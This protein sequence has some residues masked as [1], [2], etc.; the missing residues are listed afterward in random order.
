MDPHPVIVI[1][2]DNRD[3]IRVL[4]Y[5]YYTTITGW[6]VLLRAGSIHH[7]A[8]GTTK[9]YGWYVKSLSTPYLGAI[10]VGEIDLTNR[11]HL[12]L[13]TDVVLK[14]L[15]EGI[16]NGL[17]LFSG[18]CCILA[19]YSNPKASGSHHL[20]PFRTPCSANR[21]GFWEDRVQSLG[22]RV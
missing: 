19:R 1:I 2:R 13:A 8:M 15:T 5:S 21:P 7:Q 16:G 20:G 6:G 3:Y 18:P 12:T 14:A 22:C 10:S 4:L 17:S 9:D 11:G